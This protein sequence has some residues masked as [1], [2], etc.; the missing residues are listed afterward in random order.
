MDKEYRYA[1][2]SSRKKNYAAV[3]PDGTIEVKGLT[4]KKSNV[5]LFIKRSFKDVLKILS[6]V[7]NPDE[8]AAAKERVRAEL[9]E[10]YL[11]LKR[12]EI[13][14]EDLAFH[15]M[16]SKAVDRYTENTPQHVKAAQLLQGRGKEMKPGD[17]ISFVKTTNGVGVKPVE[18]ARPED[19]DVDKYVEVHEG[20]LRPA[21]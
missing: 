7:R 11:R 19:I 4:G 20:D 3:Y 2:F 13:P 9:R 10:T 17:V 18:L 5:P 6:E 16:M 12:R 8:F 21:P 14:M 1:A 15:V